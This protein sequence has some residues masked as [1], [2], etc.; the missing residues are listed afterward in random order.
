M[1]DHPASGRSDEIIIRRATPA[2][3]SFLDSLDTRLIGEAAVQDVSDGQIL[4]F[5]L[6]YTRAALDQGE[7]GAETLIALDGTGRPLAYIH[8]EPHAD[9]L[10]GETSAYISMLAVAAAAG[11]RGI[12]TRLM[13]E[14]ERWAA[15]RGYRFLLLDVFASNATARQFYA[16]RG[17]VDESLRLRRK[18]AP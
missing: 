13:A 18:V 15:D 11:G 6:N 16:R 12:A 3:R 2:D 17:F 8:L 9:L 1:N 7:P 4:S 10:T 14:A 5:Q